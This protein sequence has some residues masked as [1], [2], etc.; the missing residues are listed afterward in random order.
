[1]IELE[2]VSPARS[3]IT[4]GS[5]PDGVLFSWVFPKLGFNSSA[6]EAISLDDNI[7]WS[8]G[9]CVWADIGSVFA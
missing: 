2:G 6:I 9:S 7:I 1:M 8:R 5:P 3:T 4:I